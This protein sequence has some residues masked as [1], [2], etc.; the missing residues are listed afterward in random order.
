[1]LRPL[2]TRHD[3]ITNITKAQCTLQPAVR[4]RQQLRRHEIRGIKCHDARYSGPRLKGREIAF[5][6]TLT[7]HRPLVIFILQINEEPQRIARADEF[8][9]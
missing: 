7:L 1:M 6:H 8:A 5:A 3:K 4:I 9:G 2:Q